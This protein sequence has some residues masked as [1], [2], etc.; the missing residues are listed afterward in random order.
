MD[1]GLTILVYDNEW[2][3]LAD[4]AGFDAYDPAHAV[5]QTQ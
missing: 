2:E 1:D 3:Q 4:I 5:R